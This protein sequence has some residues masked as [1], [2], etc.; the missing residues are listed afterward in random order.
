MWPILSDY[1]EA[2][3]NPR[4]AFRDPAL[5]AATPAERLGMPNLVAGAFAAVCK[6]T[7]STGGNKAWAV[8]C[9][10]H[11]FD[12]QQER[13]AAIAAALKSLASMSTV[14]FE[15][16]PDGILV[17]G[18]GY[19]ILKME[20]VAGESLVPYVKARRGTEALRHLAGKFELLAATLF[21]AGIAHGDLQHGNVILQGDAPRLIDY[22]GMY[23]P[24]L[25]GRGSHES[26][27]ANF[28]HPKRADTDFGPTTDHFSVWAI[29]VALHALSYDP[30]LWD[31]HKGG[32]ERLLFCKDDFDNP[33]SSV[34]FAELAKA[35]SAQVREMATRFRSHLKTKPLDFPAFVSKLPP[36]PPR[37]TPPPHVPGE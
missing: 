20:W 33:G 9:F 10:L 2:F 23:V 5:Q 11:K 4:L 29:N 32:D 37:V 18:R 27:H 25:K 24:A 26:G 36:T 13:Y 22:D 30:G 6:M 3:Q 21:A 15:Y 1:A 12:D 19:P 7:E 14:G 28:R 8:R 35:G 16:L 31:R 34:L 17:N